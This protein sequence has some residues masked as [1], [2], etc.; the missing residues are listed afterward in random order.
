MRIPQV[1]VVAVLGIGLLGGCSPAG[2][3]TVLT[4]QDTVTADAEARTAL[5]NASVTATTYF[6]ST[7]EAQTVTVDQLGLRPGSSDLA[8]H[9]SSPDAFCFDTTSA[10]GTVF[11]AT[12]VGGLSEG[13]CAEGVDY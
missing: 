13:A 4:T 12:G 5:M 3:A 8:L 11:K 1:L 2:V 7:P 6:I 9:V 10:S